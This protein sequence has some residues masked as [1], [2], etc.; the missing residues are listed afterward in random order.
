MSAKSNGLR[1]V[2]DKSTSTSSLLDFLHVCHEIY[3]R[4][5]QMHVYKAIV[6]GAMLVI[7]IS[8]VPAICP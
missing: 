5:L 1:I 4:L 2:G 6:A 3:H 8:L 7:V